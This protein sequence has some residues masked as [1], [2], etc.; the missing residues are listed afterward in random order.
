MKAECPVCMHHCSID[1]GKIGLCRAR[2]N[3][4]GEIISLNYGK[5][6]SYALDPIEKKPLMRFYPGSKILSVGSYGCNLSCSFCQNH[7]ISMVKESETS[8]GILSP[9]ELINEAL[10]SRNEGNIGIAYTYNEPLIGYEY[11]RDCAKLAK[12]KGLKNVVVTNGCVEPHILEE[13][14]PYI[15]AFNIDLKGFTETFY[16]KIGGSLEL[17]KAFIQCAAKDSHIEVTTLVI[18]GENDNEEEIREI[19]KWLASIDADIPYH[20]SRFFPQWKMVDKDATDVRLIYD[21]V[22]EAKI[23]LKYVYAGNC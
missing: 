11:V 1:E 22:E 12:E 18:P 19:A 23:Y 10:L 16:R 2:G 5:I 6:T 21:L 14:L 15:D 3:K 9:E 13:I 8:Y 20:I 17:V 4:D 7:M